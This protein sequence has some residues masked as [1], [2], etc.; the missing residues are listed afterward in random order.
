M[1]DEKAKLYNRL[2][3]Q[4]AS[5]KQASAYTGYTPEAQA[6]QAAPKPKPQVREAAKQTTQGV[7]NV[8]SKITPSRA[9]KVIFGIMLAVTGLTILGDILAK[10]NQQFDVI[11]RRMVAGTTAGI[12]LML[13]AIPL[14][15]IAMGLAV[16]AG[17]TTLLT[18]PEI[19]RIITK[20]VSLGGSGSSG[21]SL[22]GVPSGP[23]RPGGPSPT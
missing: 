15:T 6:P 14:P 13:L 21:G 10:R 18:N 7:V 11:P 20:V 23:S 19:A 8:A 1:V 17:I 4:G 22:P 3:N 12:L 2:I 5:A 16:L 9:Q